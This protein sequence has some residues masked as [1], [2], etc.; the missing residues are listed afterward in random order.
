MPPEQ[1]FPPV[2]EVP[3]L[4]QFLASFWKF[5]QLPLQS[6]RPRGQDWHVL[7][8]HA[9]PVG[10]F[11]LQAPQF[12]ASVDRFTHLPLQFCKPV[13]QNSLQLPLTQVS[14]VPHFLV[15]VPQ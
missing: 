8:T 10:H 12:V 4:P 7:L 2:Q 5:T 11:V 1:T 3:H 14:P 13:G 6:V 15:Q 9:W